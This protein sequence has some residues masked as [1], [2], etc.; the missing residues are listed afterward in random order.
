MISNN[1]ERKEKKIDESEKKK[2]IRVD[3][4]MLRDGRSIERTEG[5]EG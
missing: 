2:V 3:R 1:E 4:L 5:I